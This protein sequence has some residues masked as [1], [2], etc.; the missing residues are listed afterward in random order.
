MAPSALKDVVTPSSEMVIPNV[1]PAAPATEPAEPVGTQPEEPQAPAAPVSQPL[2]TLS[3]EP[4]AMPGISQSANGVAVDLAPVTP[5]PLFGSEASSASTNLVDMPVVGA[6]AS[7]EDQGAPLPAEFEVG[8]QAPVSYAELAQLGAAGANTARPTG[9]PAP[10]YTISITAVKAALKREAESANAAQTRQVSGRLAS[11][12]PNVARNIP[13][14]SNLGSR[15]DQSIMR[16]IGYRKMGQM[17]EA[18][19]EYVKV[20]ELDPGNAVA[21]NNLADIYVARNERLDEAVALVIEALATE[22]P[23]KGPY[24]STLGWAYF[25]R[26]EYENAEKN[27]NEAIKLKATA[28]RLY[29]RGKVFAALGL[30]A[31]ARADLDRALVYSEDVILTERIRQAIDEISTPLSHQ[32]APGNVR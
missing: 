3:W 16:A 20:L 11:A 9:L 25:A 13:V 4:V 32:V 7:S 24:Y 5:E 22:P 27:L 1:T 28:E 8:S 17:D 29:R 6:P 14:S 26:G 30:A 12:D 2:P 18:I 21:R 15:V 10:A 31:K 19:A 23:D